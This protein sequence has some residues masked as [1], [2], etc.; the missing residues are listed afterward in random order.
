M[1]QDYARAEPG[2]ILPPDFEPFVVGHFSPELQGRL[3]EDELARKDT[4][5]AASDTF[6][7]AFLP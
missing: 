7:P 1:E 3:G 5:C 6:L 2:L 4:L